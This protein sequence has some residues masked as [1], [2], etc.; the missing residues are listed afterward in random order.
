MDTFAVHVIINSGGHVRAARSGEET[1]AFR[2]R[3][4]NIGEKIPGQK[5][6]AE[7]AESRLMVKE[8][9]D[10][11]LFFFCPLGPPKT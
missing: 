10:H 8:L 6:D 5:N 1:L 4:E 7:F 9:A 11:G 3:R 2:E